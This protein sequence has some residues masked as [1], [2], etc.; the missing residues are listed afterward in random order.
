MDADDI[1]SQEINRLAQHRRFGFN[2]ANAP[3]NH[4]QTIDH[5][6]MRIGADQTVRII[7]S[8]LSP[9]AFGE[10]FEIHLMTNTDP[11]RDHA[12][13]VKGLHAPLE[14]LI[15]GIVAPKLHL[16]VLAKSIAGTRE[17]DLY[18]MVNN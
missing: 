13:A 5:R 14:K 3:T 10:V 18:G 7:Y 15:A 16:H 9:N 17:V 1:R 12:E 8:M 6:G 4:A 11:R 2:A